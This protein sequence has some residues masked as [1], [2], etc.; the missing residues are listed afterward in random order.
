[1]KDSKSSIFRQEE[2]L[3]VAPMIAGNYRRDLVE[4]TDINPVF[5]LEKADQ[6]DAKVTEIR[7]DNLYHSKVSELKGVTEG[8]AAEMKLL[9]KLT[10]KIA[11]YVAQSE[12]T[13]TP[14]PNDFSLRQLRTAIRNGNVEGIVS[15]GDRV[16]NNIEANLDGLTAKGFKVEYLSAFSTHIDKLMSDNILQNN[17]IQERNQASVQTKLLYDELWTM[18][19][20]ICEAGKIIYKGW[21][22]AKAKEY[23]YRTLKQRVNQSA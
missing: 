12:G 1:M 22:D 9:A 6:M 23:T 19:R 11:Y 20:E 5:I 21:D 16:K 17:L 18:I 3:A 10:N 14:A 13:I 4:F 15:M 2:L 8:M 7:S